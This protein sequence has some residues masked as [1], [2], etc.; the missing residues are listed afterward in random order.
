MIFK[1][2]WQEDARFVDETYC[3]WL[4]DAKEPQKVA[5]S[6]RVRCGGYYMKESPC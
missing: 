3:G 5:Q 1:V 2:C 6:C 4:D